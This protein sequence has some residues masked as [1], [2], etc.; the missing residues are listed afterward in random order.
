VRPF[1]VALSALPAAMFLAAAPAAANACE[2]IVKTAVA[3]VRVVRATEVGPATPLTAPFPGA[4]PI[5]ERFCRIEGLIE[6]EIG[7]ELWLPE[8]ATWNGRLLVGGVGGQAGTL[9]YRELDRGI[10][11]HYAAASTDTGHKADDRHW[12]LNRPDRA[13]N[14][15]ERANHLLA[16]KAK[17]MVA[18]FYGASARNA[19][20]VGCS[21]G[22]R[23]ALTEVQRYPEDFDGVIAGAPGVDTP[24]MSAR[25]MWEMQQH[26]RLGALV[27]AADWSLVARSA[28]ASCDALDGVRDGIID[29]PTRCGFDPGSLACRGAKTPSC[30]TADQIDAVRLLYAPLRDETGRRLD[31]GLLAGVPVS[32]TPLPEPFTPG[33]PY[34]AVSLFGD[35]VHA[36]PNWDPR[37]FDL[38]RDLPAIDRVMNLHANDPDIRRFVAR[39][40]RLILYHGWAD[41]L[42]A[43]QS[44]LAYHRAVLARSGPQAA[45]AVRLFMAPGVDHCRGGAGPDLFGGAGGDAPIPDAGHDLLSALER[46]VDRRR[47]PERIVASKSIDG[48]IVRTRPLCAWPLHA[49]Y[50]GHGSTDDASNFTCTR[51][52][53]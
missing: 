29:D 22:G 27:T 37:T 53:S 9:N 19:F 40:G 47:P 51:E 52:Q 3:D 21:G 32:P 14:Y 46:W 12:L 48:R 43:P 5:R 17:A 28:V 50:V 34:L 15:A 30:L 26:S 25:R 13:A 31:D 33:P 10:R 7:F 35:G 24:E 42:V 20:F 8:R 18:A 45:R 39:G 36:D 23:Q 1:R 41:P 4:A 2:G 38:S 49:R 44:T 6:K 16:V 11:R